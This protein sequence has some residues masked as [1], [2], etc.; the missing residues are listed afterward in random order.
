MAYGQTHTQPLPTVGATAGTTYATYI[1]AVL[2]EIRTTLDAKVTPAG[3]DMSADLSMRSGADYYGVTNAH[4]LGLYSQAAA[5]SA[6]T[7]PTALYAA[8]GNLYFNDDSGNQIQVTSAGAVNVASAGGITSAGGYGSSGVEVNWDTS[9]YHFYSAASTYSDIRVRGVKLDDTSANWIR[10]L[11]PSLSADY[12]I[13]FPAA[14]PATNNTVVACSTTG[15]LTFTATPTVTSL[16]TTG[17][18]SVGTTLGVTGAATLSSTLGVTGLITA[19]GGVTCAANKDVT[20]SGTGKIVHG[21]RTL[22]ISGVDL[23]PFDH[24]SAS[25]DTNYS[26]ANGLVVSPGGNFSYGC[27]IPLPTGTTVTNI[28]WTFVSGTGSDTNFFQVYNSTDGLMES[29]SSSASGTINNADNF[30]MEAGKAYALMYTSSGAHSAGTE[31]V[32][33][34]VITYQTDA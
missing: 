1:N 15:T 6:G 3:M 31:S 32:E 9:L 25:A 28:A 23:R 7:Y 26:V 34:I 33:K 21:S 2:S 17:A 19:T 13:T 30:T 16:T 4:R 29:D 8:G 11:A 18:V 12:T 14:V 22:V 5:L 27:T 10:L 20:L 24:A